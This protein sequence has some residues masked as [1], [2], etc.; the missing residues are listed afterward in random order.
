MDEIKKR[1]QMSEAIPTIFFLTLSGG[2][3]DAYTYILR[4]GVFANAQTGNI[5]LFSTHLLSG[6]WSIALRYLIPIFS[7]FLG[8]FL[9]EAFRAHFSKQRRIHWRQ[10]ILLLEILLLFS[11]GFI[12]KELNFLANAIVSFSCAMQV[13]TFRK[14]K[15][16]VFASTMCIGNLRSGTEHLYK[17]IHTKD[18]SF[19]SSALYYFGVIAIFA[20]GA[21]IGGVLSLKLGFKTIWISSVLLLVSLLLMFID[22]EKPDER[23]ARKS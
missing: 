14:L 18:K 4:G 19:L 2:F 5:V 16:K 9:A 11:V 1:T 17:Y 23:N 10:I 22:S 3:Q 8:I 13:Q 12:G 7:F 6:E 20:L 21:G 15:G